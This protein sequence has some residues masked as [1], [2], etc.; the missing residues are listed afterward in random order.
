MNHTLSKL[1]L[2]AALGVAVAGC[3]ASAGGS[4]AAPASRPTRNRFTGWPGV[5]ACPACGRLFADGHGNLAG[6]RAEF[7]DDPFG[8]SSRFADGRAE[9]SNGRG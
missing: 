8:N 5:V 2:C 6:G 7:I 9:F 4:A 3:H 1:A